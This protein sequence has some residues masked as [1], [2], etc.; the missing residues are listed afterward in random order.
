MADGPIPFEIVDLVEERLRD[1]LAGFEM[2]DGSI[3][4]VPVLRTESVDRLDRNQPLQV[5]VISAGFQV[6]E[7]T[8]RQVAVQESVVCVVAVRDPSTQIGGAAAMAESGP[9]LLAVFAALFHW[10]PDD[11]YEPLT[12][13]DAVGAQH[14]AGFGYYPIAFQTRYVLGA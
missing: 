7:Q 13:I 2:R 5:S 12:M 4:D 8:S 9:L 6:D 14:E 10:S 3:A 1:R 11:R